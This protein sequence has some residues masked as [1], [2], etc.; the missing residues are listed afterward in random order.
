MFDDRTPPRTL[1]GTRRAGPVVLVLEDDETTREMLCAYLA[2]NGFSVLEAADGA[3]ALSLAFLL[4]PRAIVADVILPGIDGLKVLRRLRMDE[5]T[6]DTVVVAMSGLPKYEQLAIAAG[7]DSFLAK[8]F[9]PAVLVAELTRLLVAKT[10]R[11]A[12]DG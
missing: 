5:R 8:P 12:K 7:A 9:E 6:Y 4:G 1:S 2:R 3:E 11:S 10:E